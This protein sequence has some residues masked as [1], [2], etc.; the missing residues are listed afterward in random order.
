MYIKFGN[1]YMEGETYGIFRNRKSP[2]QGSPG[3]K[4]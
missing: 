4:G 1:V 2:G 3:L